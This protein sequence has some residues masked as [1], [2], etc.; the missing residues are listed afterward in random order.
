MYVFYNDKVEISCKNENMAIMQMAV[1]KIVK[2][3]TFGKAKNDDNS[4]WRRFR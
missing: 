4:K 2:I 3:T 1:Q